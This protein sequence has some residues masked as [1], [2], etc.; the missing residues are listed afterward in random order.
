MKT[1]L[2]LAL[3]LL[4]V[5]LTSCVDTYR[6]KQY[7]SDIFVIGLPSGT[8][9]LRRIKDYWYYFIEYETPTGQRIAIEAYPWVQDPKIALDV[10]GKRHSRFD[11]TRCWDAAVNSWK[12]SKFD[13]TNV[14]GLKRIGKNGCIY[15]FN[16]SGYTVVMYSDSRP[17]DKF[18]AI[19]STVRSLQFAVSPMTKTQRE[20]AFW[21]INVAKKLAPQLMSALNSTSY[22]SISG[23]NVCDSVSWALVGTSKGWQAHICCW[24]SDFALRGL[25][26]REEI[27]SLFTSSPLDNVVLN[28]PIA[29]SLLL[30]NEDDL[31]LYFDYYD[32]YGNRVLSI[33]E[34]EE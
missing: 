21:P 25:E 33:P 1:K 13:Y 19:R 6:L 22:S 28:I 15:S 34:K 18:Q 30:R 17:D 26:S 3:F 4:S 27:S 8:K 31:T 23:Q 32:E 9:E 14:K 29:T 24:L 20:D 5:A 7:R 10:V 12:E 2:V 11:Y 16:T